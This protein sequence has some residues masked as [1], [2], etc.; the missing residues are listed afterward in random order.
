MRCTLCHVPGG[1]PSF[2]VQTEEHFQLGQVITSSHTSSLGLIVYFYNGQS[3]SHCGRV[4]RRSTYSPKTVSKHDILQP[5]ARCTPRP[6]PGPSL[7]LHQNTVNLEC[8][9]HGPDS[10]QL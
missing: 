10:R 7:D 2:L 3:I 4:V 5:T 9:M 6:S 1:R 8:L